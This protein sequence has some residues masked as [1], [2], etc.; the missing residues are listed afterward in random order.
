[1]VCSLATDGVPKWP[2]ERITSDRGVTEQ[3]LEREISLQ[4]YDDF[5]SVQLNST[6]AWAAVAEVW[7]GKDRQ[8]GR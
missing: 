1:M 2:T 4:C 8:P 3:L 6:S 5:T 7:M